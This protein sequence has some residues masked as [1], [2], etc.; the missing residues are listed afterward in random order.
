MVKIFLRSRILCFSRFFGLTVELGV[1]NVAR[2]I[3]AFGN[4]MRISE[5]RL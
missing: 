1:E 3:F 2:A 5:L 4:R